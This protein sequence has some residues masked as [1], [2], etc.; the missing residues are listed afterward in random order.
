MFY[1]QP[2]S[3][4]VA[5]GRRPIARVRRDLLRWR[6][7]GI[8]VAAC[9]ALPGPAPPAVRQCHSLGFG[10]FSAPLAC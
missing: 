8:E 5:Q 6:V 1:A 4:H 9:L 10:G 3:R 7:A 2:M